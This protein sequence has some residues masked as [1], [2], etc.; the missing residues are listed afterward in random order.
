M[1]SKDWIV[2]VF[3]ATKYS[4]EDIAQPLTGATKG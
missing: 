2:S 1:F 3:K 4:P